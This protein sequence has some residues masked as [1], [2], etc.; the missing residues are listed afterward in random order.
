MKKIA[1]LIE[2]NFEES[3]LLYPYHRFR[4]D[5]EVDLVGTEKDTEYVGKSGGLKVKSD[6]ASKDVKASDYD[7]VY[8]PGGYSPDAI[9]KCEATV[10]FVKDMHEAGKLVGAVCHG[11]WVLVEADILKGVKATSVPT[12]KTD[13]KNA[14]AN[15]VDEE[16]V[17]DQN[18]ITARTPKDL[19]VQIKTFVEELNK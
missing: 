13:L 7:A 14:G 12:I 17:V 8:I 6:L 10:K 18:I 9:R 15:W 5:F 3:E 2:N 11:P 19:P 4:E 16:T 1:V